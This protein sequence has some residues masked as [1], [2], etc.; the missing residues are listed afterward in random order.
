MRGETKTHTRA[1]WQYLRWQATETIHG[2]KTLPKLNGTINQSY[3]INVILFFRGTL[4]NKQHICSAHFCQLSKPEI[5]DSIKRERIRW[6]TTGH[7]QIQCTDTTLWNYVISQHQQCVPYSVGT[8]PA[9]F[10]YKWGDF[11]FQNQIWFHYFT[12]HR[13]FLLI[14][15]SLFIQWFPLTAGIYWYN[16]F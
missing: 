15:S 3:N 4:K 9:I 13:F 12:I 1:R 14:K 11:L 8:S 2:K 6:I 5:V 7:I 10:C 16:K